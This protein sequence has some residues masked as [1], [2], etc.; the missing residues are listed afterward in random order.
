MRA[1]QILCQV[2]KRENFQ[3]AENKLCSLKIQSL[4]SISRVASFK[5]SDLQVDVDLKR[6]DH[7]SFEHLMDITFSAIIQS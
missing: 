4:T 5:S 6:V 1:K 7:T 3:G 2:S